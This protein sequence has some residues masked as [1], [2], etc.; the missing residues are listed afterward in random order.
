MTL[1]A[2]QNTGK[3]NRY[4]KSFLLHLSAHWGDLIE[5]IKK[6]SVIYTL[7]F[8]AKINNKLRPVDVMSGRTNRQSSFTLES[9]GIAL[10][11]GELAESLNQHFATVAADIP[12]LDTS[13]L[14]SFLPSARE[15]E[16]SFVLQRLPL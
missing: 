12:P 8:I 4:R 15:L 1:L 11:E 9:D 13:C 14:L 3:E 16:E 6:K 7:I 5:Q 2:H 10:L